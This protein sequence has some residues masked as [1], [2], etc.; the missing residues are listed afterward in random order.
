M[1]MRTSILVVLAMLGS[2]P[3]LAQDQASC[4]AYFQVLRAEEGMPGLRTGLD[5]A[6]KKWWESRG[7]K[8]YPGLCLNGAVT[9]GDKPRYL[10]I[11]SKSKAIGQTSPPPAEVYGQ[12]AMAL[13]AT[14]PMTRI[15]QPRWDLASVTVI[16]VLN[17]GSLLLPPVY[18]EADNRAIGAFTG[19]GPINSLNPGS[20]KVLKAALDYLFQERVFLSKPN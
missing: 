4:K 17:D 7:Q 5:S 9:S 2:L 12:T 15:Y 18:F 6:Q 1:S 13:Q 11:W 20:R 8:Q 3:A 19:A 16:N 14:A 10:V